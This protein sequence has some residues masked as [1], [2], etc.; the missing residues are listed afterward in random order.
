M[1]VKLRS[2]WVDELISWVDELESWLMRKK[3]L[4]TTTS[5]VY[6]V[7]QKPILLR[8]VTHGFVRCKYIWNEI[9]KFLINIGNGSQ[10]RYVGVKNPRKNI[11]NQSEFVNLLRDFRKILQKII[12]PAEAYG[13]CY[14]ARLG[15]EMSKIG[16]FIPNS[17]RQMYWEFPFDVCSVGFFSE[18]N[19]LFHRSIVFS[20]RRNC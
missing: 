2:W 3:I 11:Y 4:Q 16:K 12:I 10:T 1:K 6:I 9:T 17:P 5:E 13:R 14:Y 8:L 7:F 20:P 15:F 18:E 19:F